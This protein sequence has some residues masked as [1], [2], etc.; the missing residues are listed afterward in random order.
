[1]VKIV[2]PLVEALAVQIDLK[3]RIDVVLFAP[4][5]DGETVLVTISIKDFYGVAT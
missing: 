3:I 1:M 2:A 4:A 5:S